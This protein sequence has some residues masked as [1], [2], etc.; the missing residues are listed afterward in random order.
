MSD[1]LRLFED[2]TRLVDGRSPPLSDYLRLSTSM[3]SDRLATESDAA[4]ARIEGVYARKEDGKFMARS[5]KALS[6]VTRNY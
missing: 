5:L 6:L 2:I 4:S 1:I 3:G